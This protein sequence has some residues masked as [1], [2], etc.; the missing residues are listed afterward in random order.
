LR[1]VA[2]IGSLSIQATKE[3][4]GGASGKLNIAVAGMELGGKGKVTHENASRIKFS[5]KVGQALT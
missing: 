2:W 3:G 5:V 4:G 1:R